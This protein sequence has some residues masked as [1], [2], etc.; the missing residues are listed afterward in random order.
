MSESIVGG[1]C[2]IG[3][4][5]PHYAELIERRPRLAFI[6]VHAENFF[7]AG[8][9]ALEVLAQGRSA[10]PVSLHGVG[11]GLGSAAGIDSWHL[12]RLAELVERTDPVRVSDHASFARAAARDHGIVIHGA[13]L[14]P[15]AFTPAA[16][17]ILV[18]NVDRVQERLQRRILVENL[19]AY[20]R[21]ADDSLSEPEFFNELA[22]RSGCGMLLDLN[23]IVVNALNSGAEP[24]AAA[25]NFVD[26]LTGSIV[27]EI[28]LAGH[29]DLGDIVIDDH[30]SRVCPAVW[31]VFRHAVKRLGP[32]PT[33]IEWDTDVPALDILLDEAA[34][35]QAVIDAEGSKSHHGR[36][37]LTTIGETSA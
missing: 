28:H 33:L 31:Q 32:V 1:N 36:A 25:C 20:L 24:V 26:R 4:R 21:W 35:A 5:W 8:G 9:A 17:D 30:G 22:R 10:Y 13:D 34:L 37:V 29:A 3:W 2:G 12:D 19:S 14:L 6:E 7:G 11:L 16:L 27:G 23:N 15:L 18:D